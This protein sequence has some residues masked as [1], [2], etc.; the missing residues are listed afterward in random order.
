ML[1]IAGA[2]VIN[3]RLWMDCFKLQNILWCKY[4]EVLGQGLC[5][6]W[7]LVDQIGIYGS[8][9]V[10]V[11]LGRS[12]SQGAVSGLSETSALW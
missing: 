1:T 8:A 11:G 6:F 5:I 2:E 9:P 4:R 12:H 3:A 10:K 7:V